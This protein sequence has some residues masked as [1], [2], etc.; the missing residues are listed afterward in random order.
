MNYQRHQHRYFS[1]Q[2]VLPHWLPLVWLL[3]ALQWTAPLF[4]DDN[5][6]IYRTCGFSDLI[7]HNSSDQKNTAR[8]FCAGCVVLGEAGHGFLFLASAFSA[9]IASEIKLFALPKVEVRQVHENQ[10]H[11]RAPPIVLL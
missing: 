1:R 9:P 10:F 6:F 7:Q 11:A 3:L 2:S 5:A 8:V 4:M